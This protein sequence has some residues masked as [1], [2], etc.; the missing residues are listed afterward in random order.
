LKGKW[1]WYRLAVKIHGYTR[2]DM[3]AMD[4][5]S[6]R[7]VLHERTHH[8]IEVQL[9]RI[10]KGKMEKPENF[11]R[12][13]KFLLDVWRERKLPTDTPDLQWCIKMNEIAEK[14]NANIPVKLET[15]LPEPLSNTEMETV[16][17]LLY[18]RRSIRQFTDRPVPDEM[19]R[20][21]MYAGLM[22]PQGCNVGSTRFI[23]LRSPEEWRLVRSDIPIE[24]GV[25]ILICQD[26]RVYKTLRFDQF[27]PQNIYYDAAAAADH[28]CLMAHALGL[29]A[30]WLTH[31]EKTQR[32]IRELFELPEAFITRCHLIIGWPDE[33]P[34][35]SQRMSLDDAIIEKAT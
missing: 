26:L 7:A 4:V 3:M 22:A 23:V 6:L 30:C 18:G 16:R 29:G 5:N 2:D 35:K 31:G 24:N 17:K 19:L 9:Y 34:I 8:T 10:L 11:G 33:T 20:E 1:K 12:Q 21:I 32:R 13:A 27:V 28:M 25:M 14:L 15:E